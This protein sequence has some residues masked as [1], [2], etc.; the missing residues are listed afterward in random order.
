[1]P[2]Y[3]QSKR[4][5]PLTQTGQLLQPLYSGMSHC[6]CSLFSDFG[7]VHSHLS[8]L[9]SHK[10]VLSLTYYATIILSCHDLSICC[11]LFQ[12]ESVKTED[13]NRR[14]IISYRL[15]DDMITIYEPPQRNSGIL[16]GKFLERTKVRKPGSSIDNPEFY[17][18]ADFKIG[19]KIEIFKHRFVITN[20]DQYVLKFL[21]AF[22]G[23][24][25]LDTIN[26]IREKHGMPPLEKVKGNQEELAKEAEQSSFSKTEH[27][28]R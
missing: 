18:P 12:Q 26:S 20:A 24:F 15:A 6:K 4:G 8:A 7:L 27:Q 22:P 19:A 9:L 16:G 17:T 25:P 5:K 23:K 10:K 11:L 28:W 21:E 13:K 1:M 3:H 2:Q 14:F